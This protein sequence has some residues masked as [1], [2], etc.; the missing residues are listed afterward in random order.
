MPDRT[1][2]ASTVIL[3]TREGMGS[4]D[5][6]LQLALLGKYLGL[7]LAGDLVP[8]ALCF[9]TEGV[10]LVCEGSPVLEALRSLEQR[11]CRLLVC[12]TCLEFYG[13][14]DRLRVGTA[15]A[16]PDI[17]GAQLEAAKVITV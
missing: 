1:S 16:M 6:E 9:Y 4:G 12:T 7:L 13:L 2:I 10:S 3:L 17:L 14:K 8:R 11:G 5:P 15:C